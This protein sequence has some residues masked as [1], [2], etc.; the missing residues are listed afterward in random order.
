VVLAETREAAWDALEHIDVF[1]EAR[2]AVINEEVAI[3]EGAPQLHENVPN[4]S[5]TYFK[6][7][8]GDHAARVTLHR[9]CLSNV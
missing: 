4:N 3:A 2:P 7:G 1:Y 8:G 9:W 6:T 5:T